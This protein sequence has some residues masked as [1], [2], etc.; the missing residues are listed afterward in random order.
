MRTLERRKHN[1]IETLRDNHRVWITNQDVLKNVT[2]SFYKNLHTE[3]SVV[4]ERY[5]LH[6]CFP[7]L[8]LEWI[9]NLNKLINDKEIHT[10]LFDMK[11]WKA[12]TIDGLHVGFFQSQ[13]LIVENSICEAIKKIFQGNGIPLALNI[14]LLVLIPNVDVSTSM[15]QFHPISLCTIIYKILTKVIANRLKKMLPYLLLLKARI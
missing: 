12:P 1:R 13:W 5:V 6:G 14:T 2:M 15:S 11:P 7:S 10:T 3:E 9:T 4:T 8:P